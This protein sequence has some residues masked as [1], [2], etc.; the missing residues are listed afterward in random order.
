MD[1]VGGLDEYL[2]GGKASRIKE[3][4]VE[5]WRLRWAVLNAPGFKKRLRNDERVRKMLGEAQTTSAQTPAVEMSRRQRESLAEEEFEIDDT[6]G[7]RI[8]G[9]DFMDEAPPPPERGSIWSRI[10]QAVTG[11]FRRS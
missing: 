1:K 6:T 7:R 2:I 5:G 3:L 10:S 9:Q 11:P 4:G 8:L